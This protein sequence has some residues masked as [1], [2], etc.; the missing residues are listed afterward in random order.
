MNQEKIKM[1][2]NFSIEDILLFFI[3]YLYI[4]FSNIFHEVCLLNYQSYIFYR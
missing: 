4:V 1:K 2:E 3:Y